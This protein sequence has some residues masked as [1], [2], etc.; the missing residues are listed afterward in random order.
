MFPTP[1]QLLQISQQREGDLSIT[2]FALVLRALAEHQRT[3]VLE[4]HKGPLTKSIV[5]ENG[6]PVD[7]ESNLAHER[8]GRFLVSL[9]RL[10]E[11]DFASS[12]SEALKE[13]VPLG[14]VLVRRKLLAPT[15]LYRLLQ[16]NLA[17][18]LLDGFSWH[19]GTFQI[20]TDAPE[21]ASPLKVRVHQLI[22]TGVMRFASQ[23]Q[24]DLVV[25]GLLGK[26]L[27]IPPEPPP[28]LHTMRLSIAQQRLLGSLTDS[29]KELSQLAGDIGLA[30]EELSRIIYAFGLLGQVVLD[31][32]VERL[33]REASARSPDAGKPG[34]DLSTQV[35]Q[36][37]IANARVLEEEELVQAFLAH[38]RKD[39][40][41]LLGLQEES[42][43]ADLETAFLD[44]SAR[45]QPWAYKPGKGLR[46]KAKDLFLAGVAAYSTLSRVEGR[47]EVIER[48]RAARQA[49]GAGSKQ[50]GPQRIKTDLLDSEAQFDKGKQLMKAGNYREALQYL[51]FAVDC[52]PQNGMYR[53]ELAYDRYMAD[54][55][56]AES[57]LTGLEEARRIDPNCGLAYFYAGEILRDLQRFDEAEPLL[58]AAIK[59]MSPD[60]RP[61]D[62]LRELTR[63]S[64][65]KRRR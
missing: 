56:R 47:R 23:S 52:D 11:A 46:E 21:V 7:C 10:S 42:T 15:E 40:F 33:R 31:E 61:I 2:P 24:I 6:V 65:K 55:S 54:P 5:L 43:T 57:C 45:V 18:K 49:A 25:M 1:D 36:I 48:R 19:E 29:P 4:I 58:Q 51:E 30:P 62:A 3:A 26:K 34:E 60:R 8:L 32:D 20:H 22:L 17:K 35:I 50:V 59:P 28:A 64:K 37:P 53:A 12:F 38:R 41:E 27:A 14:Q 13:E 63:Q 16:Q 39:A 9:G 44:Y